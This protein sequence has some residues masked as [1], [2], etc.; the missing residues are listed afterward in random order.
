MMIYANLVTVLREEILPFA[1]SAL[2]NLILPNPTLE[3]ILAKRAL[4]RS[5]APTRIIILAKMSSS[6]V[7]LV[8][9]TSIAKLVDALEANAL[10]VKLILTV[11]QMLMLSL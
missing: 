10:N 3:K 7:K 8:K 4:T 11:T 5:I 1:S 6:L 2:Q 9:I